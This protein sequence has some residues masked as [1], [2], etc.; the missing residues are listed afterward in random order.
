MTGTLVRIAAITLLTNGAAL[1][2]KVGDVATGKI[3]NES[4]TVLSLQVRP[5]TV[6][7]ET[8]TFSAPWKKRFLAVR[9]CP[10]GKKY[11]EY[12]VEQS[13]QFRNSTSAR[14]GDVAD[15]LIAQQAD[16][17]LTLNATP[18]QVKEKAQFVVFSE[19]F[20]VREIGE[21]KC[22]DGNKYKKSSIEQLSSKAS[23][24]RPAWQDHIQWAAANSDAAGSTDCPDQYF[25]VD[26]SSCLIAGGRTCVMARAVQ[27]A[28][29]GDCASAFR[30]TLITQCH[31]AS[32]QQAL[33]D[34]G[35]KAVCSYL[36]DSK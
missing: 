3:L 10:D 8:L 29:A 11:D 5:C 35:E 13:A 19:P 1:A 25:A 33:S 6:H 30:F 24:Q 12:E 26:L 23:S 16:D 34:A 4:D 27:A 21:S 14:I 9:K 7:P 32:A 17:T 22:P 2:L 31:N 15:G 20:K 18:C 36:R 28:K